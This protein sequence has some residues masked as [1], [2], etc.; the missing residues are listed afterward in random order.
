MIDGGVVGGGND[1]DDGYVGGG[2][3]RACGHANI[4][5]FTA[6]F[7]HILKNFGKLRRRRNVV[8]DDGA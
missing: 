3:G 7:T 6:G 2:G 8:D 5:F 1:A 4:S